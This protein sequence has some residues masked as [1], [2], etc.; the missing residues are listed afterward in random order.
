[1][2]KR[3]LVLLACLLP[4]LAVAVP[5]GFPDKFELTSLGIS[6]EWACDDGGCGYEG[7]Y[8]EGDWFYTLF[9]EISDDGEN[10]LWISGE[11][12]WGNTSCFR[13][14]AVGDVTDGYYLYEEEF[15]YPFSDVVEPF[16][17]YD[18]LEPLPAGF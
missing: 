6:L 5:K 15:G 4:H 2:L 7:T 3:L 17:E 8:E 10:R 9:F 1:M 11:D 12:A 13:Y 14:L 16:S 18:F